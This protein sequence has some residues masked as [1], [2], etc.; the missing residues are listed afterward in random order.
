MGLGP[1]WFYGID[2]LADT[3]FFVVTLLVAVSSYKAYKF[4][5]KR[6]YR[7]LSIGFVILSASYLALAFGNF[8][9]YMLETN[10]AWNLREVIIGTNLGWF[11]HSLLFL[12]GLLI[13]IA[14]YHKIINSSVQI[15]IFLLTIFGFLL[16]GHLTSGFYILT[17]I[18]LLFIIVKQWEI[19]KKKKKTPA[20]FVALGFTLLFI[21]EIV[22][23]VALFGQMYY[24]I[25][26]L[27][28]LVGFV[29]IL[30]SQLQVMR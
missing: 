26:H 3:I 24:A 29:C 13:L 20:L 7:L 30:I 23:S 25:G 22:L 21:G 18:L 2:A 11:T 4:F 6:E 12:T 9:R 10:L 16:S 8:F 14:L 17:A 1:E 28:A 15:L 19:Y 5:G 27:V